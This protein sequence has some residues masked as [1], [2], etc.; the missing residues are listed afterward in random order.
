M[1]P[2]DLKSPFI[3][4]QRNILIQDRVLYV[5]DQCSSYDQFSFPGWAKEPVFSQE[6]PVCIEYC[7]GNGAWIAAKASEN[8]HQN[9]V[10]I[11]R[12]FDRVRKIWSKLKNKQLDNLFV[13]CGEGY[14]VTHQYFPSESVE[15]VYINFPD[16]WP[17]KRHAK[18]RI[19]QTPFVTEIWRILK[20]GG[21]L[22]L[23]TDDE[24]YSQIMIE[25]VSAI[26]GFEP[27]YPSPYFI[28]DYPGYGTSYFEDLWREK[29][30]TI[31][32]HLFRKSL[33]EQ[34]N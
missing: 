9:W 30:K 8:R 32:Y 17:K 19:I 33:S 3:W 18:H 12:K 29:G 26:S 10:A 24:N 13:V 34:T 2:E 21:L 23:V 7:S 15:S 4:E 5:P 25:V 11:E 27:L 22:T 14:R 28:T 16:P 31:R 1:K 6:R 20:K